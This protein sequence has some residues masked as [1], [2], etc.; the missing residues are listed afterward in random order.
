MIDVFCN[1]VRMAFHE[2][3][4]GS[5]AVEYADA[6]KATGTGTENVIFAVAHHD[7]VFR[8]DGGVIF[9]DVADDKIFSGAGFL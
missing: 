6:P 2:F 9:H 3:F 5:V 1:I 8:R 4:A 7:G